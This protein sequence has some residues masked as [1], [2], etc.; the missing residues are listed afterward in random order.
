MKT[1]LLAVILAVILPQAS[2][3]TEEKVLQTI[4]YEASDQSLKGQ[5]A[6]ASTIKR[7]MVERNKAATEIVLQPYQFSCWKNGKPTQKRKIKQSELNVAR[8]AWALA[9]PWK[10]NHYCRFDC[11]PSWIKKAKSKLRIGEHV[12]YEL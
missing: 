8:K 6:V 5:I 2:H 9:K 4:A 12:F 3:A 11:K 1:L 7:R 10:Y